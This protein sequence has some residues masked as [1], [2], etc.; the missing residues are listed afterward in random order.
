M[1]YDTYLDR[2][3]ERAVGR[4]DIS[5][6]FDDS[7]M[8]EAVIADYVEPFRGS[9]IDAVAGIDAL[10]F[11]LG[12]GVALELNVGFFPIRKGGKL[13]IPD[14]DRLHRE[15]TDYTGEQKSLEIDA[16]RVSSG[17]RV[18]V[19][20]D[21]IE[22]AA[23]MEA[24]TTLVEQAGGTVVGIAVLDGEQNERSQ[25]IAAEYDLHTV[26]PETSL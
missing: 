26:N 4:Y 1:E 7:R 8:F 17:M 3:S 6:L 21:W 5:A 10:G 12:T 9:G 22:T 16:A 15:V 24:A 14:D 25:T 2:I 20:D 18:L 23:Q 11:V 13:P 19:V